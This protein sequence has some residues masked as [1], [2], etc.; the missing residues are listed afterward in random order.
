MRAQEWIRIASRREVVG[1]SLRVAGVVGSILIAINYADRLLLGNI[2][3]TEY[4]KMLLT[5][6]VPYAVSTYASV[7]A[8]MD[9]SRD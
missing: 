5:Y 7:A 8:I 4:V 9:I 3:S 1:R 6:C 2:G